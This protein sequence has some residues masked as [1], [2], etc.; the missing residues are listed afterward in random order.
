MSTDE[1]LIA[2]R[3]LKD[4]YDGWMPHKIRFNAEIQLWPRKNPDGAVMFVIEPDYTS[5]IMLF[6]WVREFECKLEQYIKQELNYDDKYHLPF[7]R[8]TIYHSSLLW[9]D[10]K[11]YDAE[12]ALQT[13][14]QE[15]EGILGKNYI[16][17]EKACWSRDSNESKWRDFHCID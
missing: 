3:F 16:T 6:E 7:Q 14:N 8:T 12:T 15:I 17:V 10:P 11:K 2:D 9:V 4:V 1:L 5:Q 13:V